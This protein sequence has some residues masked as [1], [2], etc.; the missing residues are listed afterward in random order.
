MNVSELKGVMTK[1][2]L[3][4][5][6]QDYEI[7]EPINV[8][9]GQNIEFKFQSNKE[10]EIV[11][12]H[13][14]GQTVLSPIALG[15]LVAHTG[16]PRAYLKKIPDGQYGTLVLPHLNYWYQNVFAGTMIRLLTIN[17]RAL[18]AIPK[19][20]FEHIKVSRVV[21]AAERQ[22]GSEIAGYHKLQVSEERFCLSILTAKE[23]EVKDKDPFNLGI[24]I[25]HDVAGETSTRI[26]PYLFRQWCSNGATTEDKLDT[27]SR[28]RGSDDMD[29]WLQKSIMEA[30]KSFDKEILRIKAL[31]E[32][33]T[34]DNTGVILNSVLEQSS[35]PLKLQKEVQS[36]LLDRGAESLYDIYNVLT[37][38]STHSDYFKDHPLASNALNDVAT[39]LTHNSKLCPTCHKQI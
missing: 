21:D 22:L 15:K 14:R 13:N 6:V 23:V 38:V 27:W 28:R 19:A 4:E 31:Q 24:R 32:I 36:V 5:K 33:P 8:E 39:H 3:L 10:D 18:A 11:L 7:S 12:S 20:N 9:A 35:V 37:E 16:M 26:S 34:N 17:N 2:Q 29:I 25:E 1:E 30:N